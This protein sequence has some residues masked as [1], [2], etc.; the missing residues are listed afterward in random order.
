[1]AAFF[2]YIV[3]NLPE[4]ISVDTL[5]LFGAIAA[6]LVYIVV[7]LRKGATEATNE[8]NDI[9]RG[10]IEDQKQEILKLRQKQHDLGNSMQKLQLQF[11]QLSSERK[12]LTQLIVMAL[13]EHFSGQPEAVKIAQK[14]VEGSTIE[15]K[16]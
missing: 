5:I 1:M 7:T 10:L 11:E 4:H 15:D 12:Q 6:G 8:S 3:M 2:Y 9:L 16:K 13:S 14:L